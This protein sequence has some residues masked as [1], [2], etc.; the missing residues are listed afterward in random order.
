MRYKAMTDYA[1]RME[2]IAFKVPSLDSIIR[3]LSKDKLSLRLDKHDLQSQISILKRNEKDH[4]KIKHDL[5]KEIS[6]INK[7]R[8]D[9]ILKNRRKTKVLWITSGAFIICTTGLI[10]PIVLMAR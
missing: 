4:N 1:K 6:E 9:L 8:T 3:V 7:K 2:L 5:L 10:I